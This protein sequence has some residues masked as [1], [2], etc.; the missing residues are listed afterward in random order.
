MPREHANITMT[1]D[2]LEDFLDSFKRLIVATLDADGNPWADAAAYRYVDGRAYFRV[3]TDTR[4]YEHIRRDGRVCCVVE[5]MPSGSS[6][7]GIKGA[8]LHGR[9]ELLPHGTGD[10]VRRALDDVPD[11]VQPDRRD[12]AVFSVGHEDS[13]SFSFEKIRYR[14]E[15]RALAALQQ[16]AERR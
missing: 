4:T 3:P 10:E 9:A 14:Y 16:E 1:P 7:Y 8:M 13:T 5:S 6:Y 15:D 11:P 2:E 12:G